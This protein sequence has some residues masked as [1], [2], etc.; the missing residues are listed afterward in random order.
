M[1]IFFIEKIEHNKYLANCM[2]TSFAL[3]NSM[4]EKNKK[5]EGDYLDIGRILKLL[6]HA[7]TRMFLIKLSCFPD[8]PIHSFCWIS[9]NQIGTEGP[10][11]HPS[12]NTGV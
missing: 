5:R 9:K 2:I 1:G 7:C 8:C 11:G 10:H 4:I 3:D 12:L 6:K